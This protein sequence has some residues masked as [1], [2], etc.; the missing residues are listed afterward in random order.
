MEFGEELW[1]RRKMWSLLSTHKKFLYWDK[2]QLP[3]EDKK[4]LFPGS[5]QLLLDGPEPIE[6]A[7]EEYDNLGLLLA[8]G[9]FDPVLMIAVVVITGHF[10][11][12]GAL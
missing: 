3:Y 11:L 6:Q 5:R 8:S 7:R 10:N 1:I 4:E 12:G 2:T 9:A